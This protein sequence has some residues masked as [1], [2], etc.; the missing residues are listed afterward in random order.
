MSQRKPAPARARSRKRSAPTTP[1]SDNIGSNKLVRIGIITFA[2]LIVCSMVAGSLAVLPLDSIFG[3]GDPENARN[4]ANPNEELI[5]DLMADVENDP[6][7]VDAILL[8]ANVM[9]NSGRLPEAI[10]YYEQAL[11]AAPDDASVRLDFARALADG[12]L[13]QDAELQFERALEMQPENQEAMYYLAD[14]YLAW[15][16]ARTDDAVSLLEQSIG[17]D[18]DAFI[19]EQAQQQLDSL[20]AT[21]PSGTSLGTPAGED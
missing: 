2:G 16:P 1:A 11:D 12:G 9:G 13:Q 7:N 14:L 4:L 15:N 3:G 18:P 20:S 10:P 17:I 21:P 5:Q 8:L 6:D 19:A